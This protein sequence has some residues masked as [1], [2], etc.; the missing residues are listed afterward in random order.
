M[1]VRPS[2]PKC[3]NARS[4][5]CYS[6]SRRVPPGSSASAAAA[7]CWP[8]PAVCTETQ[9]QHSQRPTDDPGPASG[10]RLRSPGEPRT[11]PPRP[12][13]PAWRR[14]GSSMGTCGTQHTR[15]SGSIHLSR[16]SRTERRPC[17]E[18]TGLW[19]A[20][21]EF[22]LELKGDPTM[23]LSA[24][25][26]AIVSAILWEIVRSCSVPAPRPLDRNGLTHHF[27][28]GK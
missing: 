13:R 19:C 25:A 28:A 20:G 17:G 27:C 10:G 6:S 1:I 24:K 5:A 21:K 12:R 7:S 8:A 15:E 4:R 26:V 23:R 11:P 22:M 3:A 14:T 18:S 16:R 2:S 9:T